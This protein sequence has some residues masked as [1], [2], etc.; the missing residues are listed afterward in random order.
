MA[1]KDYSDEQIS[2]I[3]EYN[4]GQSVITLKTFI[5]AVRKRPGQFIG[6]LGAAGLLRMT[7]EIFQNAIDELQRDD[8][9]C[10]FVTVSFDEQTMWIII[11]DNGRGIPQGNIVRIFTSQYTSSNY[12]KKKFDY[13]SGTNGVG[14]KVTNALSDKFIVE[15]YVLGNGVRVEFDNGV[16]WNKGECKISKPDKQ[17][18]TRVMFHPSLEVL[19]ESTLELTCNDVLELIKT[20]SPL[21]KI[22][23]KIQFNGI[24][25]DGNRVRHVVEN[26]DGIFG[27]LVDLC[28]SPFI[29]PI[30]YA[31]DNGE[32]RSHVMFTFNVD[33]S[34][35]R[36]QD[37]DAEYIASYS[38]FCP[39]N[40]A[41]SSHVKGFI[42]GYKKFFL[43]YMNKI[44]LASASSVTKGKDKKKDKKP[45][46]IIEADL[47]VGLR[48]CIDVALLEPNFTGQAKDVLSVPEMEAY[49]KEIT[50]KSLEEWQASN[51]RLFQ[52]LCK[53]FKDNAQLRQSMETQK[54]K[55]AKNYT[56]SV[57]GLPSK[58]KKPT[59]KNVELF[60]TEGDSAAGS[61]ETYRVNQTQGVF[62]IRGMI[63]NCFDAKDINECLKNAEVQGIMNI[64]T[65]DNKYGRDFD[66]SKV[67]WEKIIFATDADSAGAFIASLLLRMIL[68]LA[69]QLI[70]EGRV[71][72][73]LPPLYYIKVGKKKEY[74]ADRVALVKYIQKQFSKNNQVSTIN[75]KKLTN[76]ELEELLYH[77]VD[78]LYEL[79]KISER[80]RVHPRILEIYLNN[81]TL[82]A[83]DI[84]K[85]IKQQYRFMEMKNIN[86]HVC[87][88]GIAEGVSN[89]LIISDRM[90]SDC[91]EIIKIINGNMYNSYK[92]NGEVVGIY[93]IM[94]AY[95]ASA[96][97]NV[98]RLKGLGEQDPEELAE[99]V[100]YPGDLGNR[101][102]IQYTMDSAMKEI[103]EVRRLNSNKALLLEDLKVSRLDITD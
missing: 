70:V 34:E 28:P 25:R 57:T 87:C 49:M 29:A 18:G 4:T 79:K 32:M 9:P 78:Y 36:P 48:A 23:S 51:P 26:T 15:S 20:I 75:G 77:N 64:I 33:N 94:T 99:S 92:L 86:G 41:E 3:L 80:F 8:S 103:D 43:D 14:G 90:L 1:K 73:A 67:E 61:I 21:T 13:T 96:P 100:I 72:R 42:A 76:N 97:S 93:D 101:T 10:D 2:K 91:E 38:N 11:E 59:K 50:I 89:T 54:V 65:K 45:L 44:Y 71:Y 22:G 102:L 31:D 5:D 95:D 12:E 27:V 37:A 62:P 69:P 83:K 56:T 63:M 53:M 88:D 68:R 58:F 19:G 17:Q 85:L 66:T 7:R 39:T 6:Y 40:S 52:K 74:F 24:T 55:I 46:Q 16:P 82:P 30:E 84:C 81:R 47:R 35:N 98:M 60:I